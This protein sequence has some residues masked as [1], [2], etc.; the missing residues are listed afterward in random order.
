MSEKGDRKKVDLSKITCVK[1]KK[2]GH[3]AN[4]CPT[5]QNKVYTVSIETNSIQAINHGLLNVT[6][7]LNGIET[8]FILDTDA[9]CSIVSESFAKKSNIEYF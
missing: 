7:T 5:R 9:T 3:Y 4:K 1:C 6:G 2:T 8:K